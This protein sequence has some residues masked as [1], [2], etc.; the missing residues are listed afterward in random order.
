MSHN[1]KV[2]Q[3]AINN[4]KADINCCMC[5]SLFSIKAFPHTCQKNHAICSQCLKTLNESRL[6]PRFNNSNLLWLC[7]ICKASYCPKDYSINARDDVIYSISNNILKIKRHCA[8]IRRENITHQKKQRN[9]IISLK[10][11][12]YMMR[13]RRKYAKYRITR[14]K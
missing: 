9:T 4:L 3:E 12:M 1:Y 14:Q 11:Q 6:S 8:K 13:T 2:L 10:N 7:P 5:H